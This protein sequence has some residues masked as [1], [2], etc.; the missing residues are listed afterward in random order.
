MKTT[1]KAVLA[2]LAL[3]GATSA[4][5]ADLTHQGAVGL[6]LNPTAQIPPPNSVRVQA[7][8]FDLGGNADFIGLHGAT[9]VGGRLEINGGVSRLDNGGL[10]G[11][12]DTDFDIGAKY[13]FTRESDAGVRLAAGVGHSRVFARNTYAYLVGTKSFGRGIA[14]GRAPITGHLGVRW[15]RFKF[16]GISDSKASVYG[17]I[18]VP[19]SRTGD[20]AFVGEL[21]SKRF[22]GGRSPYSASIRYRQ[23][24]K[25]FSL[26]AGIQRIGITSDSEWFA[27][28]GYT[29]GEGEGTENESGNYT[30]TTTTT[31]VTP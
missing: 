11:D 9:R 8:Y 30:T 4:A 28:V 21:Q 5:H 14:E 22:D 15:D 20:L 29:F 31:T 24:G 12:D 19:F 18:E 6:P 25:G 26:S 2:V 23:P 16:L 1:Y 17:G 13:L 7:D 10:F 3:A 27:Q